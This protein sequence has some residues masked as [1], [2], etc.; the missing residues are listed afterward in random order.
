MR[1][2]EKAYLQL[3]EIIPISWVK[4]LKKKFK[5]KHIAPTDGKTRLNLG[6]G[7]KLLQNYINVDVVPS[8]S[9]CKPDILCDLRKL[10]FENDFADEILSVHVIEHFYRWEIEDLLTEWKRVLKPGGKIVIECPNIISAAHTILKN[11]NQLSG[12]DSQVKESL[13]V[14]Y[15]DPQWKDPYMIHRWGYSPES[16]KK[17]LED[18]GFENVRRRAAFFKQ[19][20]P[21]DMRFEATKPMKG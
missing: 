4:K 19:K 18:N 17:L 9:E 20:E 2:K 8:R 15:G 11:R 10:E 5:F 3:I 1:I 6:C 14:L 12:I 16:L 21:R 13:W 7:D